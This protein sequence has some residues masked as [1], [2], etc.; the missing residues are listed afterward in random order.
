MSDESVQLWQERLAD[1]KRFYE[2]SMQALYQ[3][4][5]LHGRQINAVRQISGALYARNDLDDLL[6]ETLTVALDT[7]KADAGSIL[8]YD[9][10]KRKLVFRYVI[11]KTEL[12][13]VEID[14][15]TDRTGRA[16]EVFRTGESLITPDVSA[17]GHNAAFDAATGYHTR[18]ILTVPLKTMGGDPI[19]V[20]QALNRRSGSFDV[21]DQE[22]LEIVSSLAATSIVTVRLAEEAQLAAVARAVGD[23]S[24]D[25]KNAL[26]PIETMVDTT[27]DMFIVPMYD[28]LGRLEQ[29]L[30]PSHPE[31]AAAVTEATQPL[32]D[33]YPEVKA[34]VMDGCADIREM[35][36]EIADYIKGAQSTNIVVGNIGEVIEER[37]RRL[38]V[39][40]R[41]RR[42]TIHKEIPE[43]VPSFP[44]DRRLIGRALYNLVNN[45]L[46]AISDSVKKGTLEL[47]PFNIYVRV[48]AVQEGDFPDGRYC[49]LVVE[50]DGPGIPPRVRE[51][52][53]TPR[54]ISTT[55]G[56]TG[57][58]TRFVKSVADA[59]GGHVGVDSEPGKGARFWLKLPLG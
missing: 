21:E 1:Q 8:L 28:D 7:V 43:N 13:G 10:D 49:R 26:T 40:A 16:A 27:I 18:N 25:I 5:D 19:G 2:E 14:P 38:E 37:L 31:I 44:F 55:P 24:H 39:V 12:I 53:F 41:N 34:S 51:S 36:S 35:V 30:Q 59:H 23:L 42:V 58:G 22:L 45:A 57:I 6:R 54:A 32:L 33:W 52:L 4:L 46:G 15:Q 20:M 29:E 3:R 48:E 9:K 56:G 17:G 47:R 11:G 50:D